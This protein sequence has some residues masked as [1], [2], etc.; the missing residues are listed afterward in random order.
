MDL[1]TLNIALL[2]GAL[3]LLVAVGAVR[4]STRIGVPSLLLYLAIGM[5]F[6]ENGIGLEFDDAQQ[7][8]NIGLIALALI[9]AAGG[10]TTP[11]KEIRPSVPPAVVLATVG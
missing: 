5:A 7:A 6:G 11:W 10:L 3:V 1:G 4:L 2:V 8:R 9:L